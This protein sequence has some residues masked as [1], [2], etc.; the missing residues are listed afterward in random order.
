M[1]HN[2]HT[3]LVRPVVE[4]EAHKEQCRFLRFIWLRFEEVLR[5]KVEKNQVSRVQ[6]NESIISPIP[7]NRTRPFPI[8]SGF[9]FCHIYAVFLVTKFFQAVSGN[10]T[11]LKSILDHCWAVLNDK[12]QV[13]KCL[14]QD[15][16]HCPY[17]T[18]NI[19]DQSALRKGLPFKT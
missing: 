17:A 1:P 18:T 12:V 11:N 4:N 3:E 13:G 16:S 5:Y 2:G 15:G 10:R 8:H 7:W 9:S 19:N 6:Q 14:S